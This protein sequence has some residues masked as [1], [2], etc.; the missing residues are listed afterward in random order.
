M[1]NDKIENLMA[2][3]SHNLKNIDVTIPS[4]KLFVLTGFVW[5]R[6]VR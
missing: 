4:D 1:R 5:F 3:G 2:H 6:K